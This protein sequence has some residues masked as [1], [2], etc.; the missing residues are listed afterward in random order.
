MESIDANT[1]WQLRINAEYNKTALWCSCGL[2]KEYIETFDA[3]N[4]K[5]KAALV[6][7]R[8]NWVDRIKQHRD[9]TLEQQML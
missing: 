4:I 8:D 9:E 5:R 3:D 6:I 2:L 1:V 7:R